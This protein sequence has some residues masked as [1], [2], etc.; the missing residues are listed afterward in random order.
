MGIKSIESNE[1]SWYS[2]L[3]AVMKIPG[4]K[5]ERRAFLEKEFSKYCEAD[6]IRILLEEGTGKAGI[7][8][9]IMDKIA[10]GAIG[11]HGTMVVGTSFVSGLPGGITLLGTI[12]ADLAQY[13]FHTLQ[14]AQKLAYIYGYPDLDKGVGDN[15]IT[16]ITLFVGVMS[17]VGAATSGI[18]TVSK[19]FAQATVKKL[20]SMALTKTAIYPMVRKIAKMLGIQLTKKTF[21]TS[22]G[23]VIPIVGGFISGGLTAAIFFPSAHRLKNTL[24]EDILIFTKVL[25]YDILKE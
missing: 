1:N 6:K 7:S 25:A 8:Q 4:V 11:F 21:G 2:V 16:M 9:K 12:P 24:R 17:G 10:D 20:S 19:M 14:V 15:F 13:Y 3:N 18:K 5:I 23:K 22:V